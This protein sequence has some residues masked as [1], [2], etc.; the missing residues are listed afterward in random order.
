MMVSIAKGSIKQTR[1]FFFFTVYFSNAFID[2]VE[3]ERSSNLYLIFFSLLS[4]YGCNR[5]MPSGYQW[6]VQSMCLYGIIL[7]VC[8]RVEDSQLLNKYTSFWAPAVSQAMSQPQQRT[9]Q[10]HFCSCGT[11]VLM[12]GNG[13]PTNKYI[14]WQLMRGTTRKNKAG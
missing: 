8:S 5:E 10:P 13:L 1:A 12:A 3:L 6:D 11:C 4:L 14:M 2:K 7:S 9:N